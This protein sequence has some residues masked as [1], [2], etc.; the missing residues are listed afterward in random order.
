MFSFWWCSLYVRGREVR[1]STNVEH[2][3][4]TYASEDKKEKAERAARRFLEEQKDKKGADRMGLK[5]FVGP[6][7]DRLTIDQL[8]DALKDDYDIRSP[9]LCILVLV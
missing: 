9:W 1:F 6:Q 8:L 7:Q 3:D 5:T 2:L 4:G